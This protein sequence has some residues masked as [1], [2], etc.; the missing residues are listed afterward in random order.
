MNPRLIASLRHPDAARVDELFPAGERAK[1][2]AGILAAA[3]PARMRRRFPPRRRLAP[4]LGAALACAVAAV[5]LVVG[6]SGPG[7]PRV[8]GASPVSFR[9]PTAGPDAGYIVATVTDPFAAQSSLDAAFRAAG[10]EIAVSLVPASPSAVGTVVEI[11]EPSSGPQIQTLT[12]G[13][14]VTGGGGP[15][16]CPIGLKIPR[17]FKGSG[18]LTLG[19]PA[20]P[21]EDYESTNSSFAPGESLHC[22]GLIGETVA[23][24]APWLATHHVTVLWRA[25]SPSATAQPAPTTATT[26]TTST[27]TS[28]SET[29]STTSSTSQS[30]PIGS[31]TLPAPGDYIDAGDPVRAGVV[32]LWTQA[33]PLPASVRSQAASMYGAGC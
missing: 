10:V 11:S 29:T 32:L 14:C 8:A 30:G 20:T 9:Y 25:P 23:Q 26:S 18:S 7:A 5:I 15:G 19:R 13:P 6:T 22:S 4:V 31:T 27:Y 24:A 16:N 1:L 28:S 33:N 2:L 3:A 21:G 12:G 17:D